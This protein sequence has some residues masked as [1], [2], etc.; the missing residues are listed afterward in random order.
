[1][2]N[3]VRKGQ[4][5]K[6]RTKTLLALFFLCFASYMVCFLT[7]FPGVDKRREGAHV[8]RQL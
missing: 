1:M 6:N 7:Y 2:T 5:G 8:W 3:I 4:I